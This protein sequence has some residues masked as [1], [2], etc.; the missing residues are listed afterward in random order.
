MQPYCLS[1][2]F[3]SFAVIGLAQTPDTILRFSHTL[4]SVVGSTGYESLPRER[5]RQR[6]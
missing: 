2:C 6:A 5:S 1:L 3:L 4:D